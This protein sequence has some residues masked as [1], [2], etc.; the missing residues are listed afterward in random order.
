MKSKTYQFF[1][2][3][4]GVT[5]RSPKTHWR[6]NIGDGDRTATGAD[7]VDGGSVIAPGSLSTYRWIA[8]ICGQ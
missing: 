1:R 7:T 6:D 8:G 4:R 2:V 5:N 3:G